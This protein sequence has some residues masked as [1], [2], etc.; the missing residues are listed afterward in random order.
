MSLRDNTPGDDT[1][2]ACTLV[3]R[4]M[5]EQEGKSVDWVIDW[6]YTNLGLSLYPGLEDDIRDYLMKVERKI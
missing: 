5:I 6:C 3:G 1:Y 2:M 4:D